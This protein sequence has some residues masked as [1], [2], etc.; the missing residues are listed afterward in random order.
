MAVKRA[1][2]SSRRIQAIFSREERAEMSSGFGI[3]VVSGE[4]GKLG[5]GDWAMEGNQLT[6]KSGNV[7]ELCFELHLGWFSRLRPCVCV[8]VCL[9]GWVDLRIETEGTQQQAGL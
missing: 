7:F 4:G 6:V 1:W 2:V 8:C 9:S 3:F 5:G